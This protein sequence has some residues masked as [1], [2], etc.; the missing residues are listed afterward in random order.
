MTLFRE[1]TRLNV[2][3]AATDIDGTQID[4]PVDLGIDEEIVGDF[5]EE[6]RANYV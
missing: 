1:A 3:A 2:S 5:D 6:S 4:T